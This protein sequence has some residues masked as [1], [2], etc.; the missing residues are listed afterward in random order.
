MSRELAEALEWLETFAERDDLTEEEHEKAK[1]LTR[2]AVQHT[3][4][5]VLPKTVARQAIK[6]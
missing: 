2:R 1:V 6:G 4:D 3:D 5:D